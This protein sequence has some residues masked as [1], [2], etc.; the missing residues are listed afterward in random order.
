MHLKCISFDAL[1]KGSIC[2]K[3]AHAFERIRMQYYL[4]TYVHTISVDQ[5]F[6]R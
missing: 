2:M 3:Q 4:K 1:A 5:L 6:S